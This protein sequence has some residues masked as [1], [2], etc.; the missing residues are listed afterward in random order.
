MSLLLV[1]LLSLVSV[2]EARPQCA[3]IR[4]DGAPD[5]TYCSSPN[6]VGGIYRCYADI[7]LNDNRTQ[8]IWGSNCVPSYSQCLSN[9]NARITPCGN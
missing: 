6:G 1:S 4:Q 9:G 3:V 8:R 7:R 2:S 5:L